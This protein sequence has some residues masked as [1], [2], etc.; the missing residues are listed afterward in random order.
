[1]ELLNR[2]MGDLSGTFLRNRM[3]DQERREDEAR[4]SLTERMHKDNLEERRAER[5]ETAG[6]RKSAADAQAAHHKRLEQIATLRSDQERTEAY[7][8]L[9]GDMNKNQQLT[10]DGLRVME[11]QFRKG[12]SEKLAGAGLGAEVKLFQLSPKD[13]KTPTPWQ[14]PRTGKEFVTFGNTMMG[15]DA[16]EATITEEPDDLTGGT[17]RKVTRKVTPKQLD[18]LMARE[19]AGP[20]GGEPEGEDLDF[21]QVQ[22]DLA[23]GSRK[24]AT[25]TGAAPRGAPTPSAGVPAKPAGKTDAQIL[26]EAADAIEKNPA[27]AEQVRARLKAWGLVPR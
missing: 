9:L 17:K 27:I 7:F 11:E 18:D 19:G 24:L 26:R 4:R 15:A 20:A 22:R 12:F 23:S 5:T 2:A 3:M 13:T 6:F 10:P 16:P 25:G 8:K 21:D 1:M 14:H